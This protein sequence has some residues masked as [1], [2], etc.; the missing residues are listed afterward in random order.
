M[1]YLQWN[2]FLIK[3]TPSF[4]I[5]SKLRE[6]NISKESTASDYKWR[7]FDQFLLPEVCILLYYMVRNDGIKSS[8]LN[9]CW[10]PRQSCTAREYEFTCAVITIIDLK[11]PVSM[12]AAWYWGNS[13]ADCCIEQRF[14]LTWASFHT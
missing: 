10:N 12:N 2:T 4:N 11:K 7:N 3:L 6:S 13:Q 1:K 9:S 5:L 14:R 8:V